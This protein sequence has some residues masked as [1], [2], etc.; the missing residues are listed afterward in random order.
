MAE[1]NPNPKWNDLESINDGFNFESLSDI[2]ASDFNKLVE[3]MHFL[4]TNY[5]NS[6]GGEL[7][8]KRIYP[9]GSI[10]LS[11]EETFHPAEA[12]GGTW[13]KLTDRFLVGAGGAYDFEAKGGA[14]SHSHG[15][16]TLGAAVTYNSNPASIII[17]TEQRQGINYTPEAKMNV[18]SKSDYT[19]TI[20]WVVPV[21]G[22][23]D[24]ANHLPPYLAVYMW[25]RTA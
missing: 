5:L 24:T 10:Y 3:N 19:Q 20:D 6:E 15:A 2:S 12:F 21:Y 7:D 1:W 18:S 14:T 22:N 8:M 25:K 16:G 13:Q 11:L 17:K 4:Y 23:T 9:V